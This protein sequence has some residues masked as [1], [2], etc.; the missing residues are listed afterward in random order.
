MRVLERLADLGHDRQGLSRREAARAHR[1]PEVD[2]VH[3]FHQQVK[4]AV[5]LA[6]VVNADDVRMIQPR[7]QPAFTGEAFGKRR[8]PG[9]RLGQDF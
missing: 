5:G 9:E 8:V 1:L 6:E 7:Q 3:K 4:E 2:A